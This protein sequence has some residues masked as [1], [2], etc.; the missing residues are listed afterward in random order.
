MYDDEFGTKKMK[1]KSSIT[2]NHGNYLS[3]YLQNYN[4][5]LFCMIL[6]ISFLAF[7]KLD[8]VSRNF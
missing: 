3:D 2:L 5:H 7:L 6:T 8:F 4:K 1:F